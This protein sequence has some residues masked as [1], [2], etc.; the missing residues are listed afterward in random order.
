MEGAPK[1]KRIKDPIYGYIEIKD[2]WCRRIID[3]PGFQRLRRIVQT[4]YGALYPSALHN[5]FAHSLG[6]YHLGCHAAASLTRAIDALQ[7]P[8]ERIDRAEWDKAVET[9]KLAC[10]LHDYGHA[11]FSHSGEFFLTAKSEDLPRDLAN[12]LEDEDPSFA[13]DV[14]ELVS[15]ASHEVMSAILAIDDGCVHSNKA[16]FAR[17]ITGC[18]YASFDSD[19][20]GCEKRLEGHE[21]GESA[22]PRSL[23]NVLI[24]ILHSNTIDVD[25]LD[26]LIRDSYVVGFDSISIDHERLLDGIRIVCSDDSRGYKV[27]FH[28]SAMSVLENVLYARDYEKKW[29]QSHPAVLYDQALLQH[30][31]R[32]INEQW[33]KDRETPLFSEAALSESG[34]TVGVVAE[35]ISNSGASAD[36]AGFAGDTDAPEESLGSHYG[37]HSSGI[38][39]IADVKT[40]RLLSDDDVV[41]LMKSCLYDKGDSLVKEYF[42]R[43]ARR[44]PIWKSE[45][46]FRAIFCE[47]KLTSA[48]VDELTNAFVELEEGLGSHGNSC[49]LNDGTIALLEKELEECNPEVH[50]SSQL[51]KRRSTLESQIALLRRLKAFTENEINEA[52]DYALICINTFKSAFAGDELGDIPINFD[53]LNGLHRRFRDVSTVLTAEANNSKCFFLYHEDASAPDFPKE[54]LLTFIRDGGLHFD[55]SAFWRKGSCPSCTKMEVPVSLVSAMVLAGDGPSCTKIEVPV[56][57]SETGSD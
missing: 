26:Y 53:P 3:R 5:R 52:F 2:D 16:F 32:V 31:I 43:S 29:I 33:L 25:R 51:A 40:V 21:E 1:I 11:P 7:E 4:S 38:S 28:K 45:A 30:A 35:G 9:F 17:C 10:L 19:P 56:S 49:L 22:L 57:P 37:E 46:E 18:R 48:L 27:A 8:G 24:D 15:A 6:V 39:A 44:H 41:F 23:A 47:T 54:K 12:L 34:A 55:P 14:P 50:P 13:Q 36:A 20:I 42:D